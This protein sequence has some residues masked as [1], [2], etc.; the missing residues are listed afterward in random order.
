MKKLPIEKLIVS[1]FLTLIVLALVIFLFARVVLPWFGG[2]FDGFRANNTVVDF[3]THF[4]LDAGVPQVIFDGQREREMNGAAHV[5][6]GR[7]YL[8]AEFLRENV[9]PFVFW[10]VRADVLF[11]S[12]LEEMLEFTPRAPGNEFFLVNNSPRPLDDA[13]IEVGGEIFVPAGLI[14]GL[15]PLSVDFQAE[16]NMVVIT[17]LNVAQTTA[18]VS[19]SVANV[20]Y[21]PEDR[22]PVAAQLLRGDEVTLFLADEEN[23]NEAY[24]RVRTPNGLLGY[25]FISEIENLRTTVP[26]ENMRRE[27]ILRDYIDNFSHHS[28]VWDGGA[29]NLIWE[30]IGNVDGNRERMQTPFHSSLNVVSP[31]WFRISDDGTQITSVAS[32]EYLDWAHG[33]GVLVWPKVFDVDSLRVREFLTNRDARR[34]AIGQIIEFVDMFDLDGININFEHLFTADLGPYKV[35]FM[36]ELAIPLRQRGVVL[37]AAMKIPIASNAHYRHDLIGRTADFVMIMA[38]DEHWSSSPV[39]GPNA[40]LPWVRWS[41]E[42]S[43]LEIPSERLILGMPFYNRIWREVVS[44]GAV[45]HHAAMG[46]NSTRAF[47]EE[48]GVAWA[49]ES[50]S[51]SY[52]GE[53]AAHED[54]ETVIY[55][56][57]LEDARSIQEKM[58]LFE[59]FNLAGIG[60]WSRRFSIDEFWDVIENYF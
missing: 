12:T 17:T 2:L 9:D 24:V 55:R 3:H 37:S 53:V 58:N 51:G 22:A 13:I 57:W 52:F 19:A 40:S 38:Y 11:I 6:D 21:W 18:T 30:D 43:L 5:D 44:T 20:R 4:G 23:E 39:A 35:Q 41:V 59:E 54:G 45:N 34:F 47:F 33:Q 14:E 27:M 32:R 60:I 49:W 48:R 8:S 46:T 25:I 16:F 10:D 36:R 29:V 7:V 50:E 56:V 31:T 15:Y 26:L 28:R 42:N 1:I